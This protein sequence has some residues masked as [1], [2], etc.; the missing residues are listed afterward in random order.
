MYKTP[1]GVNENISVII[2]IGDKFELEMVLLELVLVWVLW[3]S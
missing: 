2:N 1:I 3:A